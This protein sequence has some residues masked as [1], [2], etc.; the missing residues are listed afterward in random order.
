MK[1]EKLTKTSPNKL[2]VSSYKSKNVIIL[3][4]PRLQVLAVSVVEIGVI[5]EQS[6]ELEIKYIKILY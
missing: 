1:C 2:S 3:R 5:Q 6:E 4:W